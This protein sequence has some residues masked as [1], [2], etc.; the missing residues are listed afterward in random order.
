MNTIE[1]FTLLSV[2]LF[3][4]V[5]FRQSIEEGVACPAPLTTRGAGSLCCR[6]HFALLRKI[7]E[8]AS[9]ASWMLFYEIIIRRTV[10]GTYV[11]FACLNLLYMRVPVKSSTHF[12]VKRQYGSRTFLMV[13]RVGKDEKGKFF[14]FAASGQ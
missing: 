8:T 7:T 11:R 10:I 1:V 12:S 14:S 6:F 13:R 4:I 5:L 2:I 9:I 3:D